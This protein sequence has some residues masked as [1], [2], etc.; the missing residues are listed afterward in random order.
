MAE[1]EEDGRVTDA[2]PTEDRTEVWFDTVFRGLQTGSPRTGVGDPVGVVPFD[3]LRAG[4]TGLRR[5]PARLRWPYSAWKVRRAVVS[6]RR[7]RA[8]DGREGR[9]WEGLVRVGCQGWLGC[10]FEVGCYWVP[11]PFGRLRAG[12]DAGMAEGKEDGRVGDAAPTN[13]GSR[14]VDHDRKTDGSGTPPLRTGGV[15][16][17]ITTGRRAAETPDLRTGGV[18]RWIMTG[19]RAGR[20]RRPYEKKG[21]RPGLRVVGETWG[22]RDAWAD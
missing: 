1:E 15:G 7:G 18:G 5:T 13:G 4:S 17:W 16:R 6:R 9:G 12:S 2:A 21:K 14:P 10:A 22:R 19:R 20:G 3:R 11:A 8:H